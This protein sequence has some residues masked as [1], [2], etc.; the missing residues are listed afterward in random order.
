M[1]LF[2][3]CF[4]IIYNVQFLLGSTTVLD[5]PEN[6]QDCIRVT[7][8]GTDST[9]SDCDLLIDSDSQSPVALV[10]D[11]C[12]EGDVRLVSI[13]NRLLSRYNQGFQ[14]VEVCEK[15]EWVLSCTR[16]WY[17]EAAVV[18]RQLGLPYLGSYGTILTSCYIIFNRY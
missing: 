1:P 4:P 15:G 18:C 13:P 3:Q 9:L 14:L 11:N 12:L 5:V 16:F 8:D 2:C 7:C 6:F 17:H 10:C